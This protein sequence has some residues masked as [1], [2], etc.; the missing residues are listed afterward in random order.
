[1]LRSHCLYHCPCSHKH[2]PA[3]VQ[4]VC[5]WLVLLL[6]ST[7]TTNLRRTSPARLHPRQ[8]SACDRAFHP[9]SAWRWP[10]VGDVFRAE[11][12]RLAALVSLFPTPRTCVARPLSPH[13]TESSTLPSIFPVD[14][15]RRCLGTRHL[16]TSYPSH[17]PLPFSHPLRKPGPP[18]N[19]HRPSI[20]RGVLPDAYP[21]M[22]QRLAR[23][24][25]S[26]LWTFRMLRCP[27]ARSV[28]RIRPVRR[29]DPREC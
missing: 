15:P 16:S 17:L 10:I 3:P 2:H 26:A 14:L 9:P 12:E 29:Q 6:T 23:D 21:L 8:L 25:P 7:A 1:M 24:V 28:I 20:V 13:N 5:C 22:V 4:H 18:G 11:R 19:V 27:L